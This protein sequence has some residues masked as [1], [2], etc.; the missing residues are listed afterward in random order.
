[1]ATT[2]EKIDRKALAGPDEFQI[3]SQ[4]AVSWIES[5]RMTL[6]GVLAALVLVGGAAALASSQR[7]SAQSAAAVAF[8]EAHKQFDAGKFAEAAAAFQQVTTE[9]AGTPFADLGVLYRGHALARQ[10]DNAG[11]AAAYQAYLATSPVDYLRQQALWAL[12]TTKEALGDAPGATDAYNQ[13]RA[14]VGPFRADASLAVARLEETQGHV[15]AARA[16]YLELLKDGD[17][18][19]A[20]KTSVLAKV[21]PELRPANDTATA[22]K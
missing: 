8:R 14:I 2:H 13:S 22:P 12:G 18:D 6:I 20:T 15:D 4:E 3:A 10:G 9:R 1:M 16:I 5:H 17:L 19:P 11:A 21:P 7:K